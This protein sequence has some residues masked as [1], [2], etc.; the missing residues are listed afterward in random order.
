VTHPGADHMGSTVGAHT[1]GP[2]AAPR[3]LTATPN[4]TTSQPYGMDVSSLQ[5]N[6]DWATTAANGAKFVYVKATEDTG[7][8]NPNF[9]Q[10]Y[11]GSY[12]AGLF[13]GAYH[14][15]LPNN[16]SGATQAGYFLA[17]GGGWAPDGHT[18]PPMLDIEYNPYGPTCY[19]LTP[20]QMTYWIRDFSTTVHTR[21]GQYPTI[22]ST[23]D[24]W[25]FCTG[26]DASFAATNPLYLAN[27][28][29]SVGT[30]PAGW[31]YQTIWQYADHGIYPG[32][33]DVFNGSLDQ[34]RAFA[35]APTQ[36]A[37]ATSPIAPIAPTRSRSATP[38][39][40]APAP[41]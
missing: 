24:W 33:A 41:F 11:N 10:Q 15:A 22:Y 20:G 25:N 4:V 8:L 31:G 37:P 23:T 5:G 26:H 40:A 14:F 29:G 12:A 30:M 32:D 17:H 27:Y 18:L 13:R 36:Q 34:L 39:S 3:M 19:G 2:V 35:G 7:Y 9:A 1:P 28:S 16:S 38:S 21:T 6:V